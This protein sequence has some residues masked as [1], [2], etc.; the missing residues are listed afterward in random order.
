[1]VRLAHRFSEYLASLKNRNVQ[2]TIGGL[3]WGR[4]VAVEVP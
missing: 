3:S 2:P 1:M 4:D